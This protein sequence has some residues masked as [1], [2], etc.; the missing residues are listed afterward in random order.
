MTPPIPYFRESGA[1]VP[2]VCLHASASSSAQ[3]R[4]LSDR[5]SDRFRVL[6]VDLYGSGGSPMWPDA[7]PLSLLDEVALIEPAL[8]AA[9]ERFHLVGHSYGGAVAL[10]VALA[11]PGRLESLVLF[12]PVLFSVLMAEDAAQPAAREIASVRDD[13]VRALDAGTPDLAGARFVDYWMG[14]GAWASMPEARRVKVASAMRSVRGEWD[15]VFME[16][17]PLAAFAALE[18]PILYLTGSESP[19]SSRGVARLLTKN[20]PR[21]TVVEIEGAGHMAPVTHADQVNALIVNHLERY[22]EEAARNRRRLR[23]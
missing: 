12:E 3:W 22:H 5:V 14:T 1:G 21:V 4:P 11:H 7:R 10:R 20:L 9:G 18:V 2:V 13:T 17:A 6:A 23:N 19:A 8:A 16:P 15:A